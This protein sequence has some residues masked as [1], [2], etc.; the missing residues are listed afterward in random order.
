VSGWQTIRSV[1]A[2]A[3][4]LALIVGAGSI[5]HR[6]TA[7][8]HADETIAA[9]AFSARFDPASQRE[10]LLR[11]LE[12]P[13]YQI[14]AYVDSDSARRLP[15]VSRSIDRAWTAHQALIALLRLEAA[16]GDA[17]SAPLHPLDQAASLTPEIA[18]L[19][20]ATPEG[21]YA[22]EP[23]ALIAALHAFAS[24]ETSIAAEALARQR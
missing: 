3:I 22:A 12:S 10:D 24:A 14:E 9:M 21:V 1:S 17:R 8:D 20:K 2:A 15:E 18:S 5:Q 4:S 13:T 6:A 16:T 7:L 11:S 23:D 19:M